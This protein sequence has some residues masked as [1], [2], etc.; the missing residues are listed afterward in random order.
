MSMQLVFPC[1]SICKV[2]GG[3]ERNLVLGAWPLTGRSRWRR[4]AGRSKEEAAGEPTACRIQYSASSS[5]S[6][7]P[8]PTA[9]RSHVRVLGACYF[10]GDCGSICLGHGFEALSSGEQVGEGAPEVWPREALLPSTSSN[11]GSGNPATGSGNAA[12]VLDPST[13][14]KILIFVTR[15]RLRRD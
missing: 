2:Y 15:D 4:R 1:W 10:A 13:K 5:W 9:S 6:P 12:I 8:A 11:S 7:S 3:I 14:V